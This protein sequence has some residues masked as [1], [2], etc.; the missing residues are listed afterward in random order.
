MR[1]RA[2]RVMLTSVRF[3]SQHVSVASDMPIGTRIR[4]RRQVLGMTQSQLAERVGVDR[5][6]VSNWENGKHFPH[7]YFGKLEAV[8]AISLEEDQEPPIVDDELRALIYRKFGRKEG[9][10]AI[11]AIE[12]VFQ[13]R[14]PTS[15]GVEPS[16]SE[17][18]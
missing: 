15:P 1:T 11:G 2:A 5:T 8:L 16:G 6:A 12:G 9:W 13:P 14:D 4:K 17:D 3:R 10:I 18:P 7:R